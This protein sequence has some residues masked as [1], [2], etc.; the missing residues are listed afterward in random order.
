[1]PD[2][3]FG[4]KCRYAHSE[5]ELA[6]WD[7]QGKRSE[8]SSYSRKRYSMFIHSLF[9]VLKQPQIQH[10]YKISV[11][12]F[13]EPSLICKICTCKYLSIYAPRN[14]DDRKHQQT[15]KGGSLPPNSA[16][17]PT[18]YHIVGHLRPRS[19]YI[20]NNGDNDVHGNSKKQRI[21]HTKKLRSVKQEKWRLPCCCG[22]TFYH[23]FGIMFTFNIV[24]AVFAAVCLLFIATR[25]VSPSCW[26]FTYINFPFFIMVSNLLQTSFSMYFQSCSAPRRRTRSAKRSQWPLSFSSSS[27]PTEFSQDVG[28]DVNQLFFSL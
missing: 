18:S 20:K 17:M 7:L 12:K 8:K 9:V 26:Q 15:V 22:S 19:H 16:C 13:S 14:T 1:M 3:R 21:S 27:Q 6:A 25:P 10:T 5:D 2:C 28:L 11:N 4:Q 23:C 24:G